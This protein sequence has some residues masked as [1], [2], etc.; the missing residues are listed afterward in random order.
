MVYEVDSGGDSTRAEA[1]CHSSY[2]KTNATG[3]LLEIDASRRC[4]RRAFLFV[5]AIKIASPPR[6]RI[7][8]AAGIALKVQAADR[9]RCEH[10]IQSAAYDVGKTNCDDNCSFELEL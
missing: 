2:E 3:N 9:R 6:G 8:P 5:S 4:S 10:Q 1:H 7:S